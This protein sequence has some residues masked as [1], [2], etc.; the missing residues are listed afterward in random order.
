MNFI[1]S[2]LGPD[3]I[4]VMVSFNMMGVNKLRIEFVCQMLEIGFRHNTIDGSSEQQ[5]LESA[6]FKLLE[7]I[8]RW[9]ILSIL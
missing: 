9:F 3:I 8:L 7:V 2:I 4:Q 5:S 1:V 6:L